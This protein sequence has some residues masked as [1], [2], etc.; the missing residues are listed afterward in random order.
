LLWGRLRS[1]QLGVRFRRQEPIG[2]YIVDFAALAVGIVVEVDGETHDDP[3]A[4]EL[5]ERYLSSKGLKVLRFFNTDIFES[6][7]GVV[8]LILRTI[9]PAP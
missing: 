8:S 4:D 5:R 2:P 1:G 3:V 7:D 6:L 9:P